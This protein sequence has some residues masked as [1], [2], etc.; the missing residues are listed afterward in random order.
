M[1]TTLSQNVK[2]VSPQ[3]DLYTNAT[4]MY[5]IDQT[6]ILELPLFRKMSYFTDSM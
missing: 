4:K 1:K 2:L 5:N 3:V 6:Q